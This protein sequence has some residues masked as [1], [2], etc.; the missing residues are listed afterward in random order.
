MT[1]KNEQQVAGLASDLNRELYTLI[2]KVI[3]GAKIPRLP[4]DINLMDFVFDSIDGWKVAVF[5]D[6]GEF[7]Y[8]EHVI[9]PDGAIF[10]FWDECY[11]QNGCDNEY[12]KNLINWRGV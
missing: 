7:D 11:W 4:P 10:D 1:E 5:Y 8:V 2:L 6:G 9:T 12:R 3:E